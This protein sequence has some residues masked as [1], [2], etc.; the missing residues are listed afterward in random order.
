M[1]ID[2]RV[3][4]QTTQNAPRQQIN[5]NPLGS[6]FAAAFGLGT[7]W[8]VKPSIDPRIVNIIPDDFGAYKMSARAPKKQTNGKENNWVQNV[9]PNAAFL[10]KTNTAQA[11]VNVNQVIPVEDISIPILAPG[12]KAV[13]SDGANQGTIAAVSRTPG[14]ASITVSP[15]QG[16]NLPA[17]VAGDSLANHGPV[18]ADGTYGWDIQFNPEWTRYSNITEYYYDSI[19]WDVGEFEEVMN[20]QNWDLISQKMTQLI[21]RN[22]ASI[23]AKMW[24]GQYGYSSN[25][26]VG[27]IANYK[28]SYT[29]GILAAMAADGVL[30]MNTTSAGAVDTM[31]SIIYANSPVAG[32]K[33]WLAFG[34]D[35]KL[36]AIGNAERSERIRYKWDD[37][38]ID[39][40]VIS[41]TYFG[42][43]TVTPVSCNHWKLYSYYLDILRNDV[44]LI[45]DYGADAGIQMVSQKGVP[46]MEIIQSGHNTANQI[47]G[48]MAMFKQTSIWGAFSVE[49]R[50]AFTYGR[51]HITS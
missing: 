6:D 37:N 28:A 25:I 32:T 14:A 17:V 1:P 23:E 36:G 4:P 44:I 13:Y 43:Y 50:K 40:S 48:N 39:D 22:S 20:T 2:D 49:T 8:A 33:K 15:M 46:I 51:M 35:E 26:T 7:T 24:L 19:R 45:P 41:Y 10:I 12:L 38:K 47:N 31:R 16:V 21:Y 9:F 11:G 29:R 30:T 34:T 5:T 18:G 3:V 42:D 27:S